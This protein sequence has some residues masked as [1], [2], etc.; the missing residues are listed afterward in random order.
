MTSTDHEAPAEEGRQVRLV[1]LAPG[2]WMVLLGCGAMVLGPLFGFLVGTMLGT[3]QRT[4]GMA[5]I[6]FFLF[7]GFMVAGLGLGAALLGLRRIVR[8]R[9]RSARAVAGDPPAD[10]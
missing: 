2:F 5:P 6:F 4:L 1:P 3:D 9:R 10:E 7:V 8:D